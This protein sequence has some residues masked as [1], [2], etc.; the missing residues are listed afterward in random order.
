MTCCKYRF[1][2]ILPFLRKILE[3][4]M[5]KRLFQYLNK[6]DLLYKHQIGFKK[7]ESTEHAV[8]DFH[9]KIIK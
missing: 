6:F 9:T 8:L 4:L 1:I 2:Y 3:N 5:H 7:S